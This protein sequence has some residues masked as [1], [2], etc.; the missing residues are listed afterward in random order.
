MFRYYFL[1]IV[2]MV[3]S[4]THAN[5]WGQNG[6]RTTAAI[7]EQYLS[8]KAKRNI[9][10]L[11]G[12]ESLAVVSTYGD[13]IKSYPEMRKYGPWHYVNIAPGQTYDEAEKN[14]DG[15]L[16]YAI[17]KC[18]EV[19][20]AD[21]SSRED[22]IFYLKM[23]VHFVGDLHQP[24]HTGHAEDK[25]GN[26]IK[27]EWFGESTN[28]HSVWDTRIIESYSMS[29][30]ELVMNYGIESKERYN[31]YAR[32]A[33]LDWF[34]ESQDLVKTVYA[35]AEDGDAL[36]YSYLEEYKGTVFLQLEKG[37]IRLAAMLNEIFG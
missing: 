2:L 30:S 19:L 12:R 34:K 28:L 6:H 9:E 18:S 11:L 23:L 7:A 5:D 27:V 35:S 16:I 21:T 17:K 25:G 4:N 26:D 14:P 3:S 37:G 1:L 20:Q 29:Y 31:T 33:L 13:E 22:K 24:L 15:D 10:K 36:G 8:R 32:G